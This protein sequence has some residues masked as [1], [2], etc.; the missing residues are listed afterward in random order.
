LDWFLE[1]ESREPIRCRMFNVLSLLIA[2]E[3]AD[4][5]SG[6][7]FSASFALFLSL[8][9]N[10]YIVVILLFVDFLRSLYF[11]KSA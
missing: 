11:G 8:S 5:E 6:K 2:T 10:L 1:D 4:R 9:A 3:R 7:I